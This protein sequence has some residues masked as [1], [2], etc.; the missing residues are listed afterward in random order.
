[1]T[2]LDWSHQAERLKQEAEFELPWLAQ[3]VNWLAALQPEP[4]H[5]VDLGAGPGIAT[6]ILARRN[7]TARVTA[8]DAT[9]DF[10]PLI[11]QRAVELG[12]A[13]RVSSVTATLGTDNLDLLPADLLWASRVLHHLPDPVVGL[14]ELKPLVA[15]GGI[16]ALI[17]GGLPLRILPGGYGVSSPSF[18]AHLDAAMQDHGD[19][20]WGLTHAATGGDADWPVSLYQ[21]GFTP[22]QSKTFLLEYRAPIHGDVRDYLHD[23]FSRIAHQASDRL[24]RDDARALERLIDPDDP[25][26]ILRRA[27]VFALSASTVHVARH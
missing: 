11:M 9:A 15:E 12:V 19:D 6:S 27:D 4:G 18:P 24:S 20:Q 3:A 10:A 5:I 26:G 8:I 25:A 21:A 1:M 23:H 16:I 14:R 13:D 17:E 22:V 7:P 2:S